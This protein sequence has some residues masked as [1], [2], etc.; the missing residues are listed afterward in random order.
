MDVDQ[1]PL[2]S[3]AAQISDK[4][5]SDLLEG[6]VEDKGKDTS[7]VLD[8]DTPEALDPVLRPTYSALP[9]VEYV[10]PYIPATL[11]RLSQILIS[12]AMLH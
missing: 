2:E 7:S 12:Q 3:P 10:P 1:S 11:P 6:A 5:L 9:R 4:Y 8:Y